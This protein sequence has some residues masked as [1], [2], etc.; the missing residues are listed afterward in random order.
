MRPKTY[1]SFKLLVEAIKLGNTKGQE[2]VG[3]AKSKNTID[4]SD[5]STKGKAAVA[6]W[7]ES[8]RRRQEKIDKNASKWRKGTMKK[9][10]G[11][12]DNALRDTIIERA[13]EGSITCI[14]A[15]NDI[16]TMCD[17]GQRIKQ[18]HSSHPK[19]S[20]YWHISFC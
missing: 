2:Y 1:E 17:L 4:T 6:A 20:I 7:V 12:I 11:G 9:M 19:A 3:D 13:L 15:S 16:I 5:T 8:V 10:F 18:V 14:N